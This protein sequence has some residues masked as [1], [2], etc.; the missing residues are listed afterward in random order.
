MLP[1]HLLEILGDRMVLFVNWM[2]TWS[3]IA[4]LPAL[5]AEFCQ[6]YS[7]FSVPCLYE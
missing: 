2:L 4:S 1:I 6:L 5:C 7:F 3:A